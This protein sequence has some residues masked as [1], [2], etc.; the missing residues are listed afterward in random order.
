[1]KSEK[2]DINQTLRTINT[3]KITLITNDQ[4]KQI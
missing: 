1:M 2:S 4:F 3:N